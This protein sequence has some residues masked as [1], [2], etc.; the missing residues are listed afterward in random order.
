MSL[1][2]P[3]RESRAS[4]GNASSTPSTAKENLPEKDPFHY[5]WRICW[6]REPDGSEKCRYVPLT[7]QDLLDPQLG[8]HVTQDTLHIRLVLTLYGLLSSRFAADPDVGVF[9]DL[10][11]FFNIPGLPN[12][13]PDVMVVRGV[14]D[15]DRRR[16]S[17]RVGE[18]P[19]RI[20]MVIEV[21]SPEYRQKDYESLPKVYEKAGVDEYVI[22]EALGTYLTD[23][24]KLVGYRLGEDRRY[25]ALELDAQGG[26]ELESV[27]V[28]IAPD[29]GGW[30]LQ[31]IHRTTGQRLLSFEEASKSAE[32]RL[33]EEATARQ[34]VEQQAAEE[35]KRAAEEARARQAAERQVAEEAQARKILEEKLARLE[36]ELQRHSQH[37]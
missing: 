23:P 6:D 33:A 30:G 26:L 22:L 2:H 27:D 18:E 10:K 37:E 5:G 3:F 34:A 36:K 16:T 35:A 19:G 4:S 1:P 9:S 20:V 8:D 12:P 17:F 31:L 11:I 21:V 13:G 25:H 24:Y 32:K 28:W 7:Y 14:E 15:R 29:P